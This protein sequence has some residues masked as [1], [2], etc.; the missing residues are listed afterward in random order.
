MSLCKKIPR[1]IDKGMGIGIRTGVPDPVPYSRYLISSKRDIFILHSSKLLEQGPK[2]WISTG[3][4]RSDDDESLKSTVGTV[5]VL[6]FSL[7]SYVFQYR[8]VRYDNQRCHLMPRAIHAIGPPPSPA[9]P[10]C[11]GQPRGRAP[12]PR[13]RPGSASRFEGLRG[14]LHQS[15]QPACT[16]LLLLGVPRSDLTRSSRA[17]KPMRTLMGGD[18]VSVGVEAGSGHADKQRGS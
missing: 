4:C 8:T 15:L 9:R 7:Y 6:V 3:Y 16:R 14:A 17:C 12:G 13:R 5:R 1:P 18:I 2:A 11:R 10:P